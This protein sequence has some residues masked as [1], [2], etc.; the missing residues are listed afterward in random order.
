MIEIHGKHNVAKVFTNELDDVSREQIKNLC[1]QSFVEGSKIRLMP[2]VHAGTGC[3]IGTTMT[4]T[5]KI[6]PN[7]VGVDIGCGME[8]IV[9][10]NNTKESKDFDPARLDE[11]I[12]SE[13]PNGMDIRDDVHEFINQIDF[14]KIRCPAINKGYAQKSLGTLGGGNHFIEASRDD[15]NNLYIVI[16]SG[17]R[18]LG[19]EIAEYYQEQAWHQ[20]NGNRQVD[21]DH[22]IS[23][24]KAEG[25]EKEIQD[26]VKRVRSKM[27]TGM[28][29]ELAYVSGGLFDDYMNDM[30]ITQYFALINRK[31]MMHTILNGLNIQSER[32]FERFSTIH[33]Y[34]DTVSMILRKGAVSAKKGEK[35]I[36]P[37]NM[38][39]GSIICE[40][41]GNADW[42]YSSPHGA[43]RIMSRANAF[44]ALK[45]ED[46]KKE[47]EG[48][49]STSVNER[50]IDESPMAYK[51]MDN[52]IAHMGQTAKVLKIIKPIYNFKSAEIQNYWQKKKM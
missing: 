33:N 11:I 9:I 35:L 40:G 29:K 10:N 30:K 34:I 8:T 3:T 31:A 27:A 32:P 36:V 47:M 13:I 20:V 15:Q 45:M 23:K 22:I 14:S 42:N 49:Y 6:V 38:R 5:D 1:N 25:R 19:K 50:T 16:H 41:L 52:I 51:T 43:G 46:Y 12:H 17:S 2:D 7:L 26:T 37:M 28:S 44:M 4:I 21:I 24:L 48:I 18:H 39:D